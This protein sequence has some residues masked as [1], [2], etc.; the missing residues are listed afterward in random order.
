MIK[1]REIILA[2]TAVVLA[3]AGLGYRQERSNSMSEY[4]AE[5]ASIRSALKRTPELPEFIRFACLA[6][7]SHNTQPWQFKISDLRIEILPDLTRRIAVVDPD[8]HHLFASL[9]CAVT[10]LALAA[11]ASGKTGEIS[12]DGANDGSV[13][14]TFGSNMIDQPYLFDAITKRQSTRTEYDGRPVSAADVQQLKSASEISG[15]DVRIITDRPQIDRVRD[16]VISGNSLQMADPAFVKEL[17]AW[18]RFNPRNDNRG[19][20]VQRYKWQ[21]GTSRLAG[22]AGFRVVFYAQNRE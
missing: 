11:G 2:G 12:F 16:L 4:G 15:V 5:V 21:S 14:F 13:V 1:R 18:I 20:P 7:N 17:K 19:W 3:G 8:N 10:N 9:G 6:A 22:A